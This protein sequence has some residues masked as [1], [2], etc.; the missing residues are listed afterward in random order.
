MKKV[1]FLFVVLLMTTTNAQEVEWLSWNEA[2]E[3]AATEENPKKIFVD[4][5]TDRL[6]GR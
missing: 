1:I 3:L 5:Y 4:I 6:Y 2:A